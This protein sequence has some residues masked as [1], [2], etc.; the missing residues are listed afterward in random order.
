MQSNAPEDTR[1]KLKMQACSMLVNRIGR[2][3]GGTKIAAKYDLNQVTNTSELSMYEDARSLRWVAG[4]IPPGGWRERAFRG[5]PG[6][7]N[8]EEEIIEDLGVCYYWKQ[9]ILV[10]CFPTP[11]TLSF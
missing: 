1:N 9:L 7:S 6:G 4:R 8:N 5:R 11:S 2:G 3:F 10:S